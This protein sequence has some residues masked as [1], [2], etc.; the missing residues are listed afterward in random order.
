M[1]LDVWQRPGGGCWCPGHIVP[2]VDHVVSCC[3]TP[4]VGAV[5]AAH[6]QQGSGGFGCWFDP[7]PAPRGEWHCVPDC[8]LRKVVA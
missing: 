3:D 5:E 1:T 2:G 6:V 8:P 7:L 4:H